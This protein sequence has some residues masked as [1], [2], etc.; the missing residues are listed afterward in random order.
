MVKAKEKTRQW[1]HRHHIFTS[2]KKK[3]FLSKFCAISNMDGSK[4]NLHVYGSFPAGINLLKVNYRNTRTRCYIYVQ[5]NNK[6]TRTTLSGVFV[7]NFEHIWHLVLVFP[8]LNLN[9]CLSAG[10]H[11]GQTDYNVAH[12]T[13]LAAEW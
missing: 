3:E 13:K 4:Y 6:D 12:Y 10:F 7:V 11:A 2:G 5:I 9:K 1:N 8:L